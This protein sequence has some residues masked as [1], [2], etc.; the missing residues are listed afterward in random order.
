M[1][2]TTPPDTPP[3]SP[4]APSPPHPARNIQ[5]MSS[6]TLSD[7]L[8]ANPRSTPQPPRRST[9]P[10]IS[11]SSPQPQP[12]ALQAQIVG[13]ETFKLPTNRNKNNDALFPT[14]HAYK[15]QK[16]QANDG[17]HQRKIIKFGSL[18]ETRFSN[19]TKVSPSALKLISDILSNV[20][21]P[22]EKNYLKY[23]NFIKSNS[24]INDLQGLLFPFDFALSGETDKLQWNKIESQIES[25]KLDESVKLDKNSDLPSSAE[26]YY[27]YDKIPE[28]LKNIVFPEK[29]E[30]SII[31]P[32]KCFIRIRKWEVLINTDNRNSIKEISDCN[33]PII[34]H[35]YYLYY[36]KRTGLRTWNNKCFK[37][38]N[39]LDE[40][41]FLDDIIEGPYTKKS[42]I[43]QLH[44]DYNNYNNYADFITLLSSN[45]Y[46]RQHT[47]FQPD[48][49]NDIHRIPD[50]KISGSKDYDFIEPKIYFTIDYS[51]KTF[52]ITGMSSFYTTTCKPDFSKRY[53]NV[54]DESFIFGLSEDLKQKLQIKVVKGGKNKRKVSQVN[55]KDVLGKQRNVY[56]FVG[57]K[58]EYIKYKNKYVL[59]KKYKEMQKTKSK[60]KSKPKTKKT[61]TK[62][63]SKK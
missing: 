7:S 47:F 38:F 63:K 16:G 10:S 15:A 31:I 48:A 37:Y 5:N 54:T 45:N 36:S 41:W 62:S 27:K 59:L 9:R 21:R 4:R 28:V 1:S 26:K 52:E 13:S 55:K 51:T 35:T 3:H 44:Y 17:S 2:T 34:G 60:S 46:V 56:K 43:S 8:H 14:A 19:N 30:Y 25:I 23:F 12:Q 58:K 18:K 39:L 49:T 57:D 11:P 22:R 20:Y 24:F 6:Y 61:K 32:D 42:K 40:G 29:K 50:N 53:M 33:K